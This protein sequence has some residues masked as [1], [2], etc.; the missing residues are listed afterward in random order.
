MKPIFE[1]T[2]T[3]NSELSEYGLKIKVL[4]EPCNEYFQKVENDRKEF[5]RLILFNGLEPLEINNIKNNIITYHKYFD[6]IYSYDDEIIQKCPNAESWAFGSCWVL[7]DSNGNLI[8]RELDFGDFYKVNDKKFKVSF[9][10]SHKTELEGHQLRHY[11]PNL[12]NDRPFDVYFPQ[13]RIDV[14][15]SLF[16]DSMFHI[17]VENSRHKNYFTE[18]IIDCFITKTIPIYWGCS[19]IGEYFNT[20][21][22]ILF[23][24]LEEL[25]KYLSNISPD[26]FNQRLDI[27]E[28]NYKKAKE[29]AFFYTRIDKLIQKIL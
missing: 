27:I 8:N 24:N 29:Y 19:N 26:F 4:M 17:V 18:K 6:K 13:S 9:I 15:H 28:E 5:D 12:L 25:D 22:M 20:D 21:G 16:L 14:K 3:D 7:T 1:G 11:I 10:K 2:V 23:E